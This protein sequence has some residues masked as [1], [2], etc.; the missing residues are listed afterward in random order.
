MSEAQRV[1]NELDIHHFIVTLGAD[2]VLYVGDTIE[3]Y[4][5]TAQ[6]VFDV[7]G[8]GDTFTAALAFGIY[9]NLPVQDAVIVAN[10]MSGLSVATSGTYAI[11][12]NHFNEAMDEINEYINNRTQGIYRE[13]SLDLL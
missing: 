8:A 3:H 5:A 2:G 10:K 9:N 13:E 12:P 7:T 6:E 11:Q 4:A 1:R